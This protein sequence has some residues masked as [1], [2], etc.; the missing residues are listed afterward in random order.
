MIWDVH[1]R[2]PDLD[3]FPSWI[4]G[5]KKHRIPDPQHSYLQRVRFE[6]L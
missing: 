5:S 2:I 4:P 1:P 3:F 6:F